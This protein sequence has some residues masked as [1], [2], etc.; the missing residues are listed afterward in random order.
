MTKSLLLD[1]FFITN[2]DISYTRTL[3]QASSYFQTRNIVATQ[4]LG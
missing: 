3:G 2:T 4:L 1:A